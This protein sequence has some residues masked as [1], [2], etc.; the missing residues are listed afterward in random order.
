MSV[1]KQ[2]NTWLYLACGA[3]ALIGGAILYNALS[4]KS[5]TMQVCLDEIDALGPIQRD[6]NGLLSFNFFK[7]IFV[8]VAKHA[9]LKYSDEKKETLK[10]RRKALYEG[11]EVLYR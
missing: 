3:A 1:S 10:T 4:S 5:N 9:K 8:I 7:N 6:P 11:N 2:N